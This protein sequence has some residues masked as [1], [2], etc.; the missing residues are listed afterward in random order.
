MSTLPN[1]NTRDFDAAAALR[2]DALRTA[3]LMATARVAAGARANRV[4]ITNAQAD[5]LN[6]SLVRRCLR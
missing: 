3:G 5:G 6:P 1:N 2:A 4:A